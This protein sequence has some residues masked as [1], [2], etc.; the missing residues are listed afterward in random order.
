MLPTFV[1]AAFALAYTVCIRNVS[2]VPPDAFCLL[3]DA[4][5]QLLLLANAASAAPDAGV[6]IVLNFV[7]EKQKENAANTQ[8]EKPKTK[9]KDKRQQAGEG[10]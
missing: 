2:T 10:G 1:G 4:C 9:A 3:P 6:N 8:R 7:E 5:Y